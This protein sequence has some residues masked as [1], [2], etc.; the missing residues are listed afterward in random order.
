MEGFISISFY[1]F[2]IGPFLL[3][4]LSLT[5]IFVVFS[6]NFIKVLSEW[7]ALFVTEVNMYPICVLFVAFIEKGHILTTLNV[8]LSRVQPPFCAAEQLKCIIANVFEGHL[9]F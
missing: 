1:I 5:L 7:L 9:N 8:K 2:K 4:F 6:L 3:V